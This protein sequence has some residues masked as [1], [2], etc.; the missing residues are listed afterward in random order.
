MGSDMTWT[1][2][3]DNV[4]AAGTYEVLF[5]FGFGHYTA[6]DSWSRLFTDYNIFKGRL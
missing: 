2:A 6:G 1:K 3:Q 5:E 4:I